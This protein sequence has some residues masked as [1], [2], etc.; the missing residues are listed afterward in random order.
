MD[1][2]VVDLMDETACY[3]FLCHLLHP[4]GLACPRCGALDGL[5]VHRRHRA[6]VVDYRCTGCRRV[7]NAWTQTPLDHTH[8]R[9]SEIVLILRGIAQ[10]TSTA[11]LA[12]ELDRDR[13]VL[14]QLRHRWQQNAALQCPQTPLPDE[15]A[16]ADEMYQNAGEKRR[17]APRSRR[18][19]AAARQ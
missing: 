19:A 8:R 7:F 12:R 10:G 17:S 6:P 5:R 4:G 1:F 15:V 2:P 14:L 3:Q 18:P 11:R 16:E 9:P 13:G